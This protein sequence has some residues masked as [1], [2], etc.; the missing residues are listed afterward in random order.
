MTLCPIPTNSPCWLPTAEDVGTAFPWRSPWL[1]STTWPRCLTSES[2]LPPWRKESR[3][4]RVLWPCLWELLNILIFINHTISVSFVIMN[5]I[6]ARLIFVFY[7]YF[8]LFNFYNYIVQMGFLP[9]K[10]R[11]S[12]PG[13]S[14]LRQSRATQPKVHAGCFSVF[15]IHRSLT[16][17][18]GSLTCAQM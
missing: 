7:F 3:S 10:I 17:T 12:F 8:L 4:L 14:Q 1:I 16:W 18:T 6:G 11:V 9:W 5:T 15:I 2:I 13:E